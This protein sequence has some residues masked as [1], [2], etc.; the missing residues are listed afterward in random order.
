MN[1][2]SSATLPA[3]DANRSI[4]YWRAAA[5]R[6]LASRLAVVCMLVLAFYFLMAGACALGLIAND[7]NHEVGVSFAN[8]SF[9]PNIDNQQARNSLVKNESLKPDPA[10]VAIDPLAPRYAEIDKLAAQYAQSTVELKTVLPL[11][12]DKWGRSILTKV[13]KGG[14]ISIS[15]G[16]SAAILATLIGTLLGALSGYYGGRIGDLLEWFYNVFTSMPYILLVIAFA[17]VL[18][19]GI[20]TVILVL[21]FTGWTST[22]RLVRAEYIKQRGRDYILAADA[23]GASNTRRM[24]Q[25]ILPNVSPLILV[26]LSQLVVDFI[27]SEVVLSFLGFGVPTDSVSWGIMINEVAASDRCGGDVDLR[28]GLWSVYRSVARCARP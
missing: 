1:T 23:I 16:L 21:A 25:H 18:H 10:S 7:W 20:S 27:K 22:Y 15:V 17:T 4:S 5:K 8:P 26:Q 3:R 12:G 6:L 11:G 19:H 2:S 24:F 9:A 28:C 14:E 13:I